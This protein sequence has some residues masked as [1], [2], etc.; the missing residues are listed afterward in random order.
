MIVAYLYL[1]YLQE[2][3]KGHSHIKKHTGKSSSWQVVPQEPLE[4]KGLTRLLSYPQGDQL[5]VSEPFPW[6][7]Q[8]YSMVGKFSLCGFTVPALGDV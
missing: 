7:V 6:S 3:D 2:L 1:M 8:N 4:P 5:I